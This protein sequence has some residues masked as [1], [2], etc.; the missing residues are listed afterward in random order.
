[1]T[2]S[3]LLLATAVLLTFSALAVA[4]TINSGSTIIVTTGS[5]PAS[6]LTTTVQNIGGTY[7]NPGGTGLALSGA[8]LS[9]VSGV[10]DVTGHGTTLDFSIGAPTTGSIASGFAT[11]TSA[12]GSTFSF[13]DPTASL[14][15]TGSFSC[16]VAQPCFFSG[17]PSGFAFAPGWLTGILNGKPA[18]LALTVQ[19]SLTTAAVPEVGTLSMVGMGLLGIAGLTKRKFSAVARRLGMV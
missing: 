11:W 9:F 10:G 8:T 19:N 7:S 12:V 3:K 6:I 16:S 15:F 17:T 5:T 1:M 18:L 14:T 13:T 2:P 4:D